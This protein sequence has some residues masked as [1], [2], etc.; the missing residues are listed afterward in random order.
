MSPI[1]ERAFEDIT[2]Y[3]KALLKYISANDVGL[4]GG[5][6]YGYYLPKE[7]WQLFT[8][9]APTKGENS[10]HKV[11]ITWPDGRQTLSTVTWYG[12]LSRSE[13]RLTG[14]GYDFP[15]RTFDNL[16]DL[17]VLI[18]KNISEYNAYVLD[19]DED[20]EELQAALGI[21][22]IKAWAAYEEGKEQLETIDTCLNRHFREFTVAVDEF[23]EVRVFSETTR[24]AIFDCIPGFEKLGADEQLIRLIQEE[25]NLYR[26]VERKVFEPQVQRLFK[27]IDDFLQ[28]ALS[29]LQARKSRAGRSL[30]NHVEYLL[31]RE[32][33]PFQMR[34]VVEDTRP[35][36][37][38]PSVAAYN[39]PNYPDSKLFM[40]GVKTTCKD[41]W[42]QVTREAPRI[43]QKHILTFQEGI[44][45]KQLLEMHRADVILV[46]PSSLH[47]EYPPDICAL[48]S[49]NQFLDSCDFAFRGL[50]DDNGM[51]LE[52]PIVTLAPIVKQYAETFGAV[53]E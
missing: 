20:I 50:S 47:K 24:T 51:K 11:T 12:T 17:L 44:S 39:D 37:I 28:T 7:V 30:E 43:K 23:P 10:K 3:G 27:S 36:I 33:I 35:D 53:F 22:I 13:Y 8:P 42:R 40:V 2:Q 6:Q 49:V 9:Y 14:F 15:Y 25:Y 41:R 45:S 34:Q 19:L 29:I 26:M 5:H 38:I 32:G 1:C 31:Y 46:V 18:P 4:T 48:L 52:L 21:E 16:G